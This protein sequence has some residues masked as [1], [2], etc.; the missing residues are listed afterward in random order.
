MT[1]AF[2]RR[3]EDRAAY[4]AGLLPPHVMARDAEA[5]GLLR[6]LLRAV[7]GE[8]A[9]VESDLET[10]YDSWFVETCPEW[11]VPYLA[12]LVGLEGLPGDLGAGSGASRRAVVAN[13]V[14][15]RRRK[16]TVA[17]VEQVVRDVTGW[18]TRAVE[19]HRLMATTT[20]VNHVHVER[21][22]WGSVR[23]AATAELESPGVADGALTRFAHTGEVRRVGSSPLGGTGR[24]DIP[25]L[26]AFVGSTSV[27]DAVAVPARLVGGEWFIHPLGW[28]TPLFAPPTTEP[29]IEHLAVESDLAIP[30]RPRRLLA[31]LLAARAGDPGEALHLR[32][33]VDGVEL[34]AD[35]VRVCGLEAPATDGGGP[36]TGW[37]VSVDP[38]RGVLTALHDGAPATPT[39]VV[40]DHGYGAPAEVGAGT[41]DRAR[42]HDDAL[43]ADRFSG[44]A[45]TGGDHVGGQV[46]VRADA[47]APGVVTTIAQAL[48]DVTAAWADPAVAG[49]TQVVSVTDSTEYP[50]GVTADLPPESRLVLVAARWEGR[51]VQ[52]GT[53]EPPVPGVYSP[54]GVRPR[55]TG[56][57]HVSG[58]S[59]SS[60][61]VDGFV[62]EGDV[63]VDPGALG[64]LT[65][66]Q[67]TVAGSVRVDAD[68]AGPNRDVAVSVRRSVVG[69]V[70][71]ADTVPDVHVVDSVVDPD[72]AG[73]TGG[74]AVTASA[75][76]VHVA[77]STLRGAMTCH[78]LRVTSSIC[79]GIVTVLDRQRGC[80]RFSY[81][82]AGSRAPRRY[83]CVP[84][85]DTAPATA[86]GF[87]SL[88]PGSPSYASLA[89]T[90]P[91]EIRH[92]GEFG[93]EMGVH[94]HLRRPPRLDA[95]RRLVEP[96]VPAG[97][98]F[99]VF[100]S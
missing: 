87:A 46:A 4:L 52:D 39:S 84:S 15:Y 83:R 70:L 13:T 10:L 91:A 80:A 1:M 89:D 33:E 50:G 61:V 71:A 66:S 37:Q 65:V 22:T 20:H 48:A 74:P 23:D 3:R 8:L 41:Y 64:S 69:A 21:P 28:E 31:A 30:L 17:V 18:P 67:C 7:A 35:R 27:H 95:A 97:M 6:A 36:L 49:G 19:F 79:D 99:G 2:T 29:G 93:A 51:T 34:S 73:A 25:H 53:T 11:V 57:L 56:D 55:I 24:Y 38:I 77:G 98:Q 12:D 78:T 82:P 60:L 16:G 43:A 14:A 40:V 58:G 63:V 92:G 47:A 72:V 44:D 90:A 85:D 75:A 62:V 96:Y 54:E 88:E 45:D 86:P 94:H 76:S 26:G 32:V 42:A 68:G 100:G 59:G 81:L 5:D 9:V